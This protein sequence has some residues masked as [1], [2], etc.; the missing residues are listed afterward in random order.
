MFIQ[1]PLNKDIYLGD[2]TA[3]A[4]SI[5]KLILKIRRQETRVDSS[6]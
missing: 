5:F 4:T 2:P 1:N 6:G 3:D